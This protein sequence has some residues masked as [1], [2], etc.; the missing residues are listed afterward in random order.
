MP[1]TDITFTI[2]DVIAKKF[3]KGRWLY[4]VS[5]EHYGPEYNEFI[6]KDSFDLGP[7]ATL[8]G[9]PIYKE[10]KKSQRKKKRKR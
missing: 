10:K 7:G 2:K 3:V 5:Y 8:E 9:V 1:K 4:L 6:E